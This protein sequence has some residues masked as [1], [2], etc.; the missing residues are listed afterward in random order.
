MVALT[1]KRFPALGSPALGGHDKFPS[2]AL[3]ARL[4]AASSKEVSEPDFLR[5]YFSFS[6][7]LGEK[8]F[9]NAVAESALGAALVAQCRIDHLVWS[10]LS[11]FW[12][13]GGAADT[14][15]YLLAFPKCLLSFA[16]F[17][18]LCASEELSNQAY[19]LSQSP[20]MSQKWYIR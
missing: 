3:L 14:E 5:S 13:K 2:R 12:P 11:H 20:S 15:I 8:Y 4:G 10:N 1:K 6:F 18:S 16:E 19:A 9:E 17:C 7:S